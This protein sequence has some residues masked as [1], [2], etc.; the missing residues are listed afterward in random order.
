MFL[1]CSHLP[2]C[3][4]Y[5]EHILVLIYRMSKQATDQQ[6]S[7]WSFKERVVNP[8]LPT[9]SWLL[10]P[11]EVDHFYVFMEEDLDFCSS[12]RKSFRCRNLQVDSIDTH[13]CKISASWTCSLLDFKD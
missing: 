13:R 11:Q 2:Y 5:T 9:I 8:T 7:S 10:T 4:I 12:N 1:A 3:L 6:R